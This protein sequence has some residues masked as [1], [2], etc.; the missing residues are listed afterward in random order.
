MILISAGLSVS[1]TI[2]CP[3]Y[4]QQ[5]LE[6]HVVAGNLNPEDIPGEV[7]TLEGKSVRVTIS[8]ND[9]YEFWVNEYAQISPPEFDSN[10]RVITSLRFG[11]NGIIVPINKV[12]LP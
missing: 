6:Y 9:P 5:V 12:L 10:G 1:L 3:Q 4:R 8:K 11:S 7:K 2:S